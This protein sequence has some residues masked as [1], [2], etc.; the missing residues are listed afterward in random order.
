MSSE[1]TFGEIIKDGEAIGIM[2]F[3]FVIGYH[4]NTETISVK[5][6][7]ISDTFVNIYKI[8]YDIAKYIRTELVKG[9][10][11]DIV[12]GY[13][14]EC[15]GDSSNASETQMENA[16]IDFP[17][18]FEDIRSEDLG[19]T[20]KSIKVVLSDKTDKDFDVFYNIR[21]SRI[22]FVIKKMGG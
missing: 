8:H 2:D 12:P 3:K 7:K 16:I 17:E 20:F 4:G 9:L 10:F 21:D 13:E 18:L 14:G 11:F 5:Y 6:T 15:W 1:T 19:P 22:T